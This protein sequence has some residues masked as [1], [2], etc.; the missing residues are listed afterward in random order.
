MTTAITLRQVEAF[1]ALMQ[2]QTVTRAAQMLRVSQP[3][4]SRL[5]ADFE[6][7]AGLLL[8]ERHQGRLFP[9]AEAR[10]L[11]EEVERAFI[12]LDRIVQAADQIRTMHRGSLRIAG[13]PALALDLLPEVVAAFMQA[14]TG[15]EVLLL[16]NNSRTVVELVAGQRI[17]LG[18]VVEAIPHPAVALER[19][20]EG[21]MPCILPLGHRLASQPIIHLEDL[22]EE[23]FVS[24][25]LPSDARLAIDKVFAEHAVVR[26]GSIEAQLTQTVIGLVQYGAGVALI[27]PVSAHYARGRV[28]VRP[29]SPAVVDSIYLATLSGQPMPILAG[30]FLGMMRSKLA[31]MPG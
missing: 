3:A 21:A 11:Y 1:R 31:T 2:R 28:A 4:M 15:V 23:V 19:L 24:F 26:Q 22:A 6:A 20:H 16:A 18:F 14:F 5:I 9:T 8:F 27:D 10:V 17:D 25:P 13:S 7:S 29:F 12:G 30:Q